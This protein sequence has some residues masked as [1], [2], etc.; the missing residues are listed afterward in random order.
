MQDS[1]ISGNVKTAYDQFYQKHDEAWRM[2][3][4]KYKAQHIIEVCKGLTFKNVLEVGAGDGSIL[5]YLSDQNFAPEFQAVEISGSGVEY[6]KSRGIKNLTQVQE[7]DG[8]KL[9]FGDDSFDLII[10]SHVLEHVEHERLLLREIKRV[11]RH[12]VIEVPRDY[13]AGVDKRI[14]HFLAYGHI[15]VYTPTSLRYLLRTEGFEIEN[16]LISMTEPGVTRF[17]MYVNQQKTKS[18]INNFRIAA[19]FTIKQGLG[20]IFGKKV[21]EQFANA[22]TVLCKKASQQPELF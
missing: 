13:K 22:Y 5:K 18:F 3:S 20:K 9:P 15:N 6:I 4:A 8:Y 12:C 17:N 2:L 16:D 14:K 1:I 7:F 11:A 19:E 21:S 10:L